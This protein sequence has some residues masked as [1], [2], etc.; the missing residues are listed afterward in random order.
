[1]KWLEWKWRLL[2]EQVKGTCAC[3]KA[4][5][6]INVVAMYAAIM[7]NLRLCVIW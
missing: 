1:M 2:T 6:T 4:I 3:A 5:K 7:M